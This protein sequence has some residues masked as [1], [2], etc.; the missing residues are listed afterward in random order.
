[1]TALITLDD[2]T[3]ASERT[4]APVPS[5]EAVRDE[6]AA[7]DTRD[8]S[9][10]LAPLVAAPDAVRLDTTA[11]TVDEQVE[12]VVQAALAAAAPPPAR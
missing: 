4:G 1:M 3:A 7:R 10:D 9:R 6:M 11:L 12:T 2:L 5:F 8:T